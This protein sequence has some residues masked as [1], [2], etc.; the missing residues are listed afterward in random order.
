MDAVSYNYAIENGLHVAP[1]TE[2]DVVAI[3]DD[4][5]VENGDFHNL[6]GFHHVLCHV[7][8][9]LARF[10]I[11]AGMIVQQHDRRGV[12]LQGVTKHITGLNKG[13]MILN[14]NRRRKSVNIK[15]QLSDGT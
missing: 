11:A 1:F 13:K 6:A 3:A 8:I 15:I 5:V 12:V 4:D 9:F 10:R 2:A 14:I 7:Q